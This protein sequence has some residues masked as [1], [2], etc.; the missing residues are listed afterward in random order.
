MQTVKK[1]HLMFKHNFYKLKHKKF[2]AI[3]S[4]TQ[5]RF[6]QKGDKISIIVDLAKTIIYPHVE[7]LKKADLPI[8]QIPFKILEQDINYNRL[9]LK[10][11]EQ[12]ITFKRFSNKNQIVSVLIL[13][14]KD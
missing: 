3:L 9:Q 5:G 13:E 7:I 4:Q 1:N 12:Y 10:N 11:L 14:R 8:K 6:Y 2:I